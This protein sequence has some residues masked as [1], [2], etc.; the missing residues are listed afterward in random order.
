MWVVQPTSATIRTTDSTGAAWD[1]L[2]GAPDPFCDLYCPSSSTTVTSSTPIVSDTFTPAWTTGGCTIKASD[3]LATGFKIGCYDSDVSANDT[4]AP[5]STIMVTEPM[6]LSGKL[7]G[8]T[9]N[10][11]LTTLSVS[12]TRK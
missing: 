10:M 7:D 5:P 9:N 11:T 1:A 3:L 2:G 6:V 8:L 4:I 12:F